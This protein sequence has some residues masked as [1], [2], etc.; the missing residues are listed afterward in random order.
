MVETAH[1]GF[2]NILSLLLLL[3]GDLKFKLNEV[4]WG[5]AKLNTTVPI[6][7]CLC[8]LHKSADHTESKRNKSHATA[9]HCRCSDADET[10][11]IKH[12]HLHGRYSFLF[13]IFFRSIFATQKKTQ[14]IYAITAHL[15]LVHT[16]QHLSF[17]YQI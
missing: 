15:D 4:K 14:N 10:S 2:E 12:R 17:V 7:V 16:L 6:F 13:K 1:A 5:T 11:F 3:H 9:C 8:A